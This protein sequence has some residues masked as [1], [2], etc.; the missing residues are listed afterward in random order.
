MYI[1]TSICLCCNLQ[2]SKLSL[3]K[4]EKRALHMC[5]THCPLVIISPVNMLDKPTEHWQ[6][7]DCGSIQAVI[8][9]TF[10]P[11]EKNFQHYFIKVPILILFS[12]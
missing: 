12:M 10:L 11:Y 5:S 7:A 9:S 2:I 6:T 3:V 8:G 4:R 1:H